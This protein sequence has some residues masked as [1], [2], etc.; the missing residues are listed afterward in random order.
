MLPRA[1]VTRTSSGY[2]SIR[3]TSAKSSVSDDSLT[4]LPPVSS[5]VR[6]YL[7]FIVFMATLG[8]FQFG[9]HLGELNAPEKVLTCRAK[10]LPGVASSIPTSGFLPQCIPMTAPQWGLVQSIFPVGGLFGSLAAGHVA[11]KYGRILAIGVLT[12]ALAIGSATEATGSSITSILLGRF[13][14]GV[15]AGAATVVC[16]IYIAEISP[17]DKR[18]IFGAFSQVMIN[19]GILVAQV[20]GYFLSRDSLWRIILAF[21]AVASIF[22]LTALF[23]APETPA[24]LA[25]NGSVRLARITLRR[26]RGPDADIRQEIQ[27]WALEEEDEE[28]S[29]LAPRPSVSSEKQGII[30][31]LDVV[32]IP[33]YRKAVIAVTA[34]FMAQQLCG[35][36]SAVMYSVAILGDIIPSGAA[37]ITVMVSVIN[38]TVSILCAPL[39]DILGRKGCV[40]LSISGMGL[41]S[42]LLAIGL[43]LSISALTVVA[44]FA[45]V[46]SFGV[47]LGPVPFIYMGEV[48]G[49][50]AVGALSSWALAGSWLSTFAVAQF[51]PMINGA[52]PEGEAFWIFTGTALL[53]GGF[54]AWRVPETR[55]KFDSEEVWRSFEGP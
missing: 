29:L 50:E 47:G 44:L 32:T 22:T 14:S 20:M 45:F 7:L 19:A 11:T 31:F 9:Y 53:L 34:T 40:L 51:F 8:P 4:N 41:S 33:M 13:I 55:G 23:F 27:F 38:L 28:Q 36:N 52:L 49:P 10:S 6:R 3:E 17:P 37:L 18:G 54:I 25:D 30:S 24:W 5:S 48:V 1:G 35:I 12:C 21:P 16:P 46:A 42:A 26:I 43:S 2:R 15:G 39:P